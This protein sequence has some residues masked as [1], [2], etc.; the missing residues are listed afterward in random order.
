[1]LKKIIL[2]FYLMV[3]ICMGVATVIEK[4]HGTDYVSQHVYGA[5]W[6]SALWAILTA[7]AVIYFVRRKVKKAY[8]VLMHLSFVIILAG[9]LLTHI[10]AQRGVV[11]L[12]MGE[13]S[14]VYIDKGA[15]NGLKEKTLP[16]SIRLNCFSVKYNEGTR[17]A[18]D[19]V[20]EI[21]IIDN[22]GKR[23]ATVSLNKIYSHSNVRIYQ[24]SYD[25][26]AGGSYLSVNSDPYGIPVTYF[27]YALLFVTLVWMLLSPKGTFRNLLRSTITKRAMM[28]P[29]LMYS[30]LLMPAESGQTANAAP[31]LPKESADR[32]GKL[33]ILYNDRICPLETFAID[34]T[35]KL[36]GERKYNGYTAEQVL[37][38]FIFWG[39]EW[40]KEPIIKIKNGPLKESL[41]LPDYCSVN[42]F[43]NNDMGGYIIGPYLNE[44]YHGNNDKFHQDVAQT[45]ERLQL[46]MEVRQGKLMKLFP[47]TKGSTTWYAPTDKLPDYI[48]EEQ[49]QYI[50][51]IFSLLYEDALAANYGQFDEIVQ[52]M[53]KYQKRYGA[54]SVPS[55][56]RVTA[57]HL[58]NAVPMPT[59]LFMI[60][61]TMGILCL[62]LTIFN[63]KQRLP[64]LVMALS[65]AALTFFIIL[66]WLASA[67][68]PLSNGYETTLFMA[69]I[70]MLVTF[71]TYRRF[72]IILTFGFLMSGFFLLVSHISYMD[73]QITPT[74]PIL[75]S[76]LLT[77]HVS[78]IMMSY[79]LLSLTFICG[80]MALFMRSRAPEL[81][82]LSRIFLYPAITCLGLGIFIGAIWANVSWGTYWSWD[83][84]EVWALITLMCYAAA[85]H[86]SSIPM[87]RRPMPYH[88]FMIV[89]FLTIIMTFFGVNYFLGGMHSYA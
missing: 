36:Y 27:G 86:T 28:L 87:F 32:F 5:W 21:T 22:S 9:A 78:I 50:Q 39:E 42:T 20:S 10:T 3:L 67:S 24:S 6:F 72:N 77:A 63:R 25:E 1:M 57:E 62:F 18:T 70:I 55:S 34:F 17:A 58:Y 56:H 40:S 71:V 44:Y 48:P 52:K 41:Q 4:Y 61:L 53:Q 19:Y 11:H 64:L 2:F 74:M 43:F 66:R 8:I 81:Q 59:I 26:D 82:L 15:D 84:K 46:I 12:R 69:W 37:T 33:L 65:F 31:V 88:I 38:G 14:N 13:T 49:K 54:K 89:A 47:Y 35:K 16:F 23:D 45:D 85:L 80:V 73:P 76:P 7:V 60:N 51:D 75:I 29:L 83:P 30:T 68:I 79:A